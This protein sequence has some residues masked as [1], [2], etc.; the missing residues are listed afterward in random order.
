[1]AKHKR[2]GGRVTPKGT[3]PPHLKVVPEQDG[4]GS[5]LDLIIDS[6]AREL[7]DEDDPLA[8]EA[9]A[10]ALLDKFEQARVQ[11]RLEGMEVPAFEEDLLQRCRQ[12]ADQRAA[13]VAAALASVVPPAHGR[14]AE[15]VTAHLRGAATSSPRW[16]GTIG[17][18][19]PTRAWV[20]SD[21]F[22]DQDS[23]VIGFRQEGRAGE[24][25]LVVLVDHNLSGQAKDA[26]LGPELH[27]VVESWKSATDPHI[28]VEEVAL[29][30]A[31]GR[32]RDAMAMSDLWNGDTDLR[33]EDFAEH[34]A[35][36][37]AR[38]RRANL[39]D[40]SPS[41][42]GDISQAERDAIVDQFLVSP[43]GTRL[44][45]E[46]YGVDVGLLTRYIVGLRCDYEGRPYRWSPTV[47]SLLL[48]A[49]APS[50]LLLD[51]DEA[52]A[53]PEVVRSFARFSAER[54]GLESSLVD[55]I[56][57]AVDEMEPEF[58]DRIG[59]PAAAGPA[60]ALLA[61]LEARG[62]D[63]TDLDAVTQALQEDALVQVPE[64]V[65]KTRPRADNASQEVISSAESAM[66]LA[67]FALLAGFYGHGRKLTQTGQPTLADAKE[68]VSLMETGDRFDVTIGDRTYKTKSAAELPELGF[69]IRWALS[70][71]ALRK[72]HGKLRA[73]AAWAKLE[74]KPLQRW[75]KAAD[76][77]SSL[78]PL[79]G[80]HATNRYRGRHEILDELTPEV[81]HMLCRRAMAFDEVLDWVCDRADAEYEW[82]S[83]YMQDPEHRRSVF[84]WDL[85]RVATIM[86]WA[87]ITDRLDAIVEPDRYGGENI[88]GGTLQLTRVGRWWLTGR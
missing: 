41:D 9:W 32:L 30:G 45:R 73:T 44:T 70:A 69:T 3:R 2:R 33:T 25:A 27:D 54:T 21:P 13:V 11:A 71:G 15:A 85:T 42:E 64:P 77:L 24:H 17:H 87:G 23:L 78:G 46:Q 6:G 49:L 18:V 35:L 74:D 86:G 80:F 16:L 36:I 75:V 48:G 79:A 62:V 20:A 26:W 84:E 56:L 39:T 66:S 12:R 88:V 58:L 60:K 43:E 47:V 31:L 7:L 37:W 72:E 22:G 61:A 68:L 55:E 76:A 63:V 51:A 40:D 50:K 19:T 10:S 5:P 81:L 1:M 82:L 65:S 34:R 28:R 8:A 83:P 52:A 59:D 4:G 57:Q 67:R 53:L 29:V 14:L 38:L